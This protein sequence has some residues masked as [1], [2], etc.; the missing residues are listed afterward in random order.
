MTIQGCAVRSPLTGCQVTS[1]PRDRFSRYS[2]WL[3]TFRTALVSG[4]NLLFVFEL[5]WIIK[6]CCIL[7]IVL[8]SLAL[9]IASSSGVQPVGLF[10]ALVYLS[11]ERFDMREEFLVAFYLNC[12]LCPSTLKRNQTPCT[13]VVSKLL[14][15]GLFREK[16]CLQDHVINNTHIFRFPRSLI[17]PVLGQ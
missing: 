10:F 12:R 6:L 4:F 5:W 3:D 13:A 2:K 1:R 16:K 8:C 7:W 17:V 9:L 11:E 15:R 14:A